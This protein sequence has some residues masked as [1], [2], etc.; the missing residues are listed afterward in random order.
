MS[1]G[2]PQINIVFKEKATTA[3]QRGNRGIVALLLKDTAAIGSHVIIDG[4]DI[5]SEL[6]ADNKKQIELALI[7][8]VQRPLKVLVRIGDS[9]AEADLT[10]GLAWAETVKFDYLV[11]PTITSEQNATVKSWVLAQRD[12]GK[13]IKAV[14]PNFAG[15]HEG[16]INFTTS[17]IEVAG[18]KYTTAEYCSRI[19]G[20]IAGTP[21]KMATTFQV[22]NE[23]D[24]VQAYTKTQLD[25]AIGNGE[26][27]IFHDGEKV[28]VARGVNSLKT[29]TPDKSESFKKIK[30]VDTMDLIDSDITNTISDN[31]IGKYPNTYDNKCI[32]LT[33]IKTY[34]DVLETEPLLDP[35][36][37]SVGID[38]TAQRLFLKSIG[39]N[40]DEMTDQQIKE[41]NTKDKV[42]L[43]SSIKIVDAIEE[44]TLVNNL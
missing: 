20:L 10:E 30:I 35:G 16:I 27:V 28:K 7:G 37:N 31:Y 26:F 6:S 23:V 3:I 19:A 36:K 15:D 8:G 14:V 24:S 44:I 25:D 9:E 43:N 2:L 41:A 39:V 22:L 32:V 5:P 12:L 1:M 34:Y 13:K 17:D 42:F 29:T 40:V 18:T 4:T 11:I 21:L 33:A 38:V